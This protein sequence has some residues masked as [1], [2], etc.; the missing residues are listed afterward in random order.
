MNLDEE[1]VSLGESM[2]ADTR[3]QILAGGDE[4]LI[5]IIR[6]LPDEGLGRLKIILDQAS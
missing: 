1:E 2:A 6:S 3:R 4:V 5:K